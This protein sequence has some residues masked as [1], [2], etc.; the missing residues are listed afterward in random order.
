MVST[1]PD[2]VGLDHGLHGIRQRRVAKSGCRSVVRAE[3]PVVGEHDGGAD[4]VGPVLDEDRVAGERGVDGGRDSPLGRT[5]ALAVAE[6][7]GPGGVHEPDLGQGGGRQQEH[8]RQGDEEER[9]AAT[10]R[11]LAHR[12]I[13][14]RIMVLPLDGGEGGVRPPVGRRPQE[15]GRVVPEPRI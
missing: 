1:R 10:Q 6:I 13:D 7:V 11:P 9:N 3:E 14:V 2:T 8:G 12:E 5:P 4:G 15:I